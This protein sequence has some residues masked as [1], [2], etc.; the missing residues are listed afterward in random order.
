M[1]GGIQMSEA[2]LSMRLDGESALVTGAGRGPGRAL[3]QKELFSFA[4]GRF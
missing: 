2:L 3:F 1:T 4:N